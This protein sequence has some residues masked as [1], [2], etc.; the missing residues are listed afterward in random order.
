MWF[1]YNAIGAYLLTLCLAAVFFMGIL[2]YK[3][4]TANTIAGWFAGGVVGILLGASGAAAAVFLLGYE[5]QP[6]IDTVVFDGAEGVEGQGGGGPGG[7]GGGRGGPAGGGFEGGDFGGGGG[8]GGGAGGGGRGARGGGGNFDPVAIFE[9]QDEDG[10]GF[11]KDD[12]ISEWMRDGL[13]ETDTDGDGTIS[14]AEFQE[15]IQ[16]RRARF[17]GGR[18]GP[19]GG[20]GQRGGGQRGGGEGQRGGGARPNSNRPARPQMEDDQQS[21]KDQDA[22]QQSEEQKIGKAEQKKVQPG[23]S[24]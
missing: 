17:G 7:A 1:D 2:L 11:L 5:L 18:G 24:D 10:D 12:E 15:H 9:R 16:S 14:L 19:G 4:R 20:G 21:G 23:D 22:S 3:Q 13:E 8:R 6:V